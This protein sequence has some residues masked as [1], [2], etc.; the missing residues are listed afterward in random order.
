[1][2][3]RFQEF[4]DFKSKEKLKAEKE[5]IRCQTTL[6]DEKCFELNRIINTVNWITG[7]VILTRTGFL[8]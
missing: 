4:Q 5:F 3:T 8:T 7:G 1:M 6:R 2:E